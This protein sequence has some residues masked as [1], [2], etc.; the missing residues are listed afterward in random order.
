MLLEVQKYCRGNDI[1]LQNIIIFDDAPDRAAHDAPDR[2]A[3]DAPDRAAHA[4]DFYP[5]RPV[6]S[7]HTYMAR[8]YNFN[9]FRQNMLECVKYMNK[10]K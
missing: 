2:A 4:D 5:N 6:A 3:H 9:H 7:L 10:I 8:R 1:S